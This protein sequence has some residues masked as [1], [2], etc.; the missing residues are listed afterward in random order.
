MRSTNR[1][2]ALLVSGSVIL[3]CMTIIVGMT[4]ALFTDTE[5]V[6]NHLKAG[7]LDITLVRESL[8][9][10]AVYNVNS[11][12]AESQKFNTDVDGGRLDFSNPNNKNIFKLY[13]N[14][15]EDSSAELI[16]PGSSYTAEMKI[17][18]NDSDVDFVYWLGVVV[19][20][21]NGDVIEESTS[22]LADVV[23][24]TVVTNKDT[25]TEKTT[26]VDFKSGF[27][28]G[29]PD[30]PLGT[31]LAEY[32]KNQSQTFYVTM[33]FAD[34]DYTYDP[35]TGTLTSKDNAAMGD[36]LSF[37]IVVYAVQK[38]NK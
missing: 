29:K 6:S 25:A 24:I 37:D 36:E 34:N 15:D 5:T 18:N 12:V 17:S 27:E 7:D 28:I 13:P 2:R 10:T 16:L 3:L 21:A 30:Q 32:G 22:D 11:G 19:K 1:K 38:T 14:G 33:T 35:K 9:K 4:W 26:S 20:D 31:F 23:E 8:T